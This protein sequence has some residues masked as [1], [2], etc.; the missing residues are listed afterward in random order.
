MKFAK[1]ILFEHWGKVDLILALLGF[2]SLAFTEHLN[3]KYRVLFIVTGITLALFIKL[4]RQSYFYYQGMN[5][6]LKVKGST[7]GEGIYTGKVIIRIENNG[8]L[9]DNTLLTLSCKGSNANQTICIL[10]VVK[11]THN[12][13]L[14]AIQL[15]PNS[16]N[17]DI[18]K[19]LN[20]ESRLNSL[21]ALPIIN[22][23]EMD[24]MT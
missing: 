21:F 13:D 14:L 11:C 4:I 8:Q 24:N 7:Q 23:S 6:P 22:K 2:I 3:W 16:D 12:E 18:K 10:Q 9:R 17:Y 5:R 1:E 15:I 20:E 19:Y